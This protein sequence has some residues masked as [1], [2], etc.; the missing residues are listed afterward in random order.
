VSLSPLTLDE[1][2]YW[3]WSQNLQ[4]SYY[5]HPAMVAWLFA[6]GNFLPI[7]MLK[8][9]AVLLGHSFFLV[10]DQFIKKIGF[11]LAQRKTFFLLAMVS[12][13]VGMSTLV[14]TPDLPLLF[15]LSLSVYTFERALTLKT[16][17]WYS[18]FGLSLGL[19]FTSKYHIVLIIPGILLYLFVDKKWS[20]I[21]WRGVFLSLLGFLIGACPVLIWNSQ[22]DWISF[23]FQIEHGVG[24]QQFNNAWPIEFILSQLMILTPLFITDIF[25]KS[26][27]VNAVNPLA[28]DKSTI[29]NNTT[30]TTNNNTD[31]KSGNGNA[32]DS[33]VL[34]ANTNAKTNEIINS[35]TSLNSTWLRFFWLIFLPIM[36]FFVL[37]SFKNKVEAN[38]TQI[39]FPFILSFLATKNLSKKK[40]GLYLA[41]WL[42]LLSVLLSQWRFNWWKNPPSER[43]TEPFRYSAVLPEVEQ[44]QPFYASTYQMASYL[45]FQTR[46]P[47]FKLYQT[48]RIDFFDYFPQA[49]PQESVFYIAKPKDTEFPDWFLKLN[50]KVTVAKELDHEMQILRV[51][52]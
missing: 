17:T 5:D 30:A 34:S 35:G 24:S 9:P 49:K 50:Y 46:K 48:S 43:L 27:P 12:P 4:L 18:L 45:W 11:S 31:T 26:I 33:K 7:F 40:I 22:N 13:V 41:F 42:T 51:S 36:A 16:F 38:W 20:Q 6:I 28:G 1:N 39:A 14:L 25:K 23:K 10:W 15:F 21:S 3:V 2:Y 52:K 19:G 32:F 47:T 8:W 37:N 29:G 44:Y